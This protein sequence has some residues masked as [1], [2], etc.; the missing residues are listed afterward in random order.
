M[1]ELTAQDG[2]KIAVN[3]STVWHVRSA[4]QEQTA[5]YAAN[6]AALFVMETCEEVIRLFK[7]EDASRAR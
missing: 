4:N 3:P 7:E 5:I 6:G 1:I 2:S